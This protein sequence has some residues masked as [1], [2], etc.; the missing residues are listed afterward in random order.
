VRWAADGQVVFLGR[1]DDQV[2]VR[3]YRIEPGEIETVLLTHP[4]VEQ[5]AVLAREDSTGD[6]RL[7]AYV[8]P[9]TDAVPDEELRTHAAARLPE[10]M[11]PATVVTLPTLP[12][13]T[14]GK[15]DRRALPDPESTGGPVGREPTTEQEKQLCQLYAE[16][17]ERAVVGVDDSF[18]DIGGHSL[19][20]I[21][22][23]SRIRVELGAEVKIRTLFESPTPAQLAQE[24]GTR[25]SNRPALRRMRK[26][27]N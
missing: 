13:T 4:G 11:V 17:L 26:E 14:S 24:L 6:R 16:V 9:A 21:R 12:M 27:T 8:V 10:Y 18:F 20:A 22:L 3:G 25:K 19:L 7:I 5:V 1:V 2:K 15:L 23:L